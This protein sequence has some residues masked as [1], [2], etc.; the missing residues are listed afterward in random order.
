MKSILVC[1]TLVSISW[2]GGWTV[3]AEL[4]EASR[5]NDFRAYGNGEYGYE[6]LEEI[7][8]I[9]YMS[10]ISVD[11]QGNQIVNSLRREIHISEDQPLVP[12]YVTVPFP[13]D[14]ESTV[15]FAGVT[16]IG[17]SG[18]TLWT[19]MLDSISHRVQTG[20]PVISCR[21]GG[22]FAVFSPTRENFIWKAYRLSDSGEL[23]M[24]TEFQ[25]QGGPVISVSNVLETSDSSFLITGT[26]DDLGMNLFM[27]LIGVD[28]NGYQFIDI[29]E[30]FR[31]HAG[32]GIIEVDESGNI[33]I[34]GYTGDERDDG[35]FMP[36]QDTDVFL[37]K[38]D[39]DGRE[40]WRTVFEYPGENTPVV[41]EITDLGEVFMVIKSFSY[42]PADASSEYTLL[43][44][45][46]Q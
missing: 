39:P 30:Y 1:F 21:D 44:Y 38:L 16:R 42:D 46:Q 22:C 24:S 27:F 7:D 31:F 19:V 35:Y 32:A 12:L 36:P 4:P 33:Y 26:T 43:V 11:L 29:K 13:D 14:I 17:A 45:Q 40:L 8:G 10:D 3:L 18:D 5:I 28:R 23:Q 34:A 2:G 37:L 41:I 9:L 25:M 6:L 20:Q 15:S